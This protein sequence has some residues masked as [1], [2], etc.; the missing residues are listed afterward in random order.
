[1][2]VRTSTQYP[3]CYTILIDSLIL[4]KV[5]V[6]FMVVERSPH[7]EYLS[8]MIPSDFGFILRAPP[9]SYISNIFYLPF[10][11]VVWICSII[12]V[13]LCMCVIALTL[14]TYSSLDESVET[15]SAFDY[16][17]FAIASLCQKGTNLLTKFIS[18]R[19]SLV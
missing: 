11:G 18:V 5:T 13:T 10:T 4:Q 16:V 7:L 6:I 1:M 8:V 19:I 12:L 15:M 14:R 17:L 3:K 2:A 9:I